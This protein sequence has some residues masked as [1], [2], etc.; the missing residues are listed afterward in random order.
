MVTTDLIKPIQEDRKTETRRLRGLEK[1][2]EDPGKWRFWRTR[3]DWPNIFLFIYGKRL[4]FDPITCPY[5]SAGD[6]LWVRENWF[7]QKQWDDIKPAMLPVYVHQGYIADGNK[8]AWGGKTRSSIHLP[9]SF[10]RLSL[11]I[12]DLWPERLHDI[13]EAGAKAEGVK[14]GIFRDGPN[15]EKGEFQLEDNGNHGRYIDGFKFIWMKLNGRESWELNPWVWVI[16]FKRI[17]GGSS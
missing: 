16:K 3:H 10:S 12:V 15:T 14:P 1:I 2:N 5:G 13:T 11:G 9:R 17:N 6:N 4:G 8:P 7:A